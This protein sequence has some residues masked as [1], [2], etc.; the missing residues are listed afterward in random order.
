MRWFLFLV[1]C[2]RLAAAEDPFTAKFCVSCHDAKAKAGGLVL[3]G[4]ASDDPAGRPDV[5]EKVVKR[6]RAGEM[7]P[8][9]APRPDVAVARDFTARLLRA[10]DDTDTRPPYAGRPVIRRLN[11]TEYANA[12]RDLLG[13]QLPLAAELPQDQSIAGFDNI[14]DALALSPLLLERYLKVARRVSEIATGTGDSGPVVEIFPAKGA[15]SSWQ[16]EGMPFGTRGGIRVDHYFPFDGDYDL[17]AFLVKESLTPTEGVRFFR[18]RLT[19]VKAGLHRAIVTFPDEFAEHEGP[20]SDVSGIGGPARGGPLDVLGTAVRPTIEF[21]LDGRRVKLFEIRGMNAGEAAFDGQ[22]GPPALGRIEIAGPYNAKP[23]TG[24]PIFTCRENTRVCAETILRPLVRRAFRRDINE[25]DL[26]PYLNT[27]AR[28]AKSQPLETAIAAPLRD[29]LLAPDF[30]FRLEFDP[31]DAPATYEVKDF[32]LASRLSFFLWSSIPDDQL[33][34]AAGAGELRTPAGLNRQVRRMLADSKASALLDNF[35]TQ[36]LG[37]NTI[38]SAQPDR[39]LFPAYDAGLAEAFAEESRLFVSSLIRE[40]RPVLD[41]IN[42]RYTY[43][44]ERLANHYGV[45]GVIGPGFRRV[46]LSPETG[47]GGLLTQGSVLLLTSHSTRTS[48]V[49]RGKWILDNLL[50]SPPPPPPAAVPPLDESPRDGRKLTAR[51]QMGRHRSQPGCASCH[52]R[53]DPLGF[54]LENYDVIGRFRRDDEGSP[55]DASSTLPSGARMNGADGLKTMLAANP[56]VLAQ[57]TVERLLTYAVGQEVTARH[58]PAVRRI[59][60]ETEGGGYRFQD[61]I[62]AVTRSVPF[63]MKQKQEQ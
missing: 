50:N 26:A 15:Q 46:M 28:A 41:L 48:P 52:N 20:V 53:I 63:R 11:R 21:R 43:L 45:P 1:T 37:L 51:E 19:N 39:A 22:P 27:Y 12:V 2:L 60:R 10:L 23:S 8:V 36:W 7:P 54:T 14:A 18:H 57:A 55:I 49:L 31:P 56:E 33:L 29:V 38:E 35:A 6:I 24:K 59:L 5:W 44:N 30:L 58:Q 16:G 47:R 9:G 4:L 3:A 32:E 25:K 13:L 34:T 61:L 62:A 40:S 42:A 17:R